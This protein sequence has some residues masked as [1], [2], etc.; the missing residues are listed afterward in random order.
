MHIIMFLAI[1]AS[2]LF[3]VQTPQALLRSSAPGGLSCGVHTARS[4]RLMHPAVPPVGCPV[5]ST[6]HIQNTSLTSNPI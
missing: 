6:L 4:G 5:E 1:H 2:S 3:T